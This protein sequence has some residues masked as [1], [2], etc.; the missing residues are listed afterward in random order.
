MF[1][2]N[3]TI[4][5]EGRMRTTTG[6]I[7]DGITTPVSSG[8]GYVVGQLEADDYWQFVGNGRGP[9]GMP[10]VTNIQAWMNRARIQGSAYAIAKNIA[11]KGSRAYREKK[12]NVFMLGTDK[13]EQ[14]PAL[15][16]ASDMAALQIEDAAVEVVRTNMKANG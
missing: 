8:S 3:R 7:F 1:D 14:S 13:W 2:L 16:A 10:P 15:A 6:R 9:G 12:P 4:V 11:K 5:R